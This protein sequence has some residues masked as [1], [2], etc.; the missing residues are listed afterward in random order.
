MASAL[1]TELDEKVS[2]IHG[3]Y[4]MRFADK[5]RLTRSSALIDHLVA[6]LL[7]VQGELRASGVDAGSALATTIQERL[8]LYRS[9]G[10]QIIEAQGAGHAAIEAATL[11]NAADGIRNMYVRHFSDKARVTRDARLLA[12]LARQMGALQKSMFALFQGN[13]GVSGLSESLESLNG[14]LSLYR[15]ETLAIS[16]SQSTGNGQERFAMLA[17]RANEQFK[18]YDGHFSGRDRVSRRNELQGDI[19]ANLRDIGA[20]MDRVNEAE[21]DPKSVDHHRRNRSIVADRLKA[22]GSE[23]GAIREAQSGK[24]PHERAGAIFRNVSAVLNTYNKEFAGKDR[25]SRDPELIGQF[26][27]EVCFGLWSLRAY[28]LESGD[29]A[30]IADQ[31]GFAEDLLD[32]LDREYRKI[33]ESKAS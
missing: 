20:A 19:V 22:Y 25:K 30:S 23:E 29:G 31:I 13:P 33:V 1:R 3:E 7:D 11:R 26:S 4:M 27:D 10:V 16:T 6:G 2:R 12:E 18:L 28:A 17:V 8:K 5:A 21:L 32:L 15:K 14:W 9:E 24:G